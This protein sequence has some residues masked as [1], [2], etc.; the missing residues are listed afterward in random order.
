MFFGVDGLSL[1]ETV[2]EGVFSWLS[3][4]QRSIRHDMKHSQYMNDQVM[5]NLSLNVVV[6]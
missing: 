5:N 4:M 2:A 6:V 3:L 1:T